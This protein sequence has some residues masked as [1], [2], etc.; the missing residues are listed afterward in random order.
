MHSPISVCIR[1][2]PEAARIREEDLRAV[3][4]HA[5]AA[6]DAAFAVSADRV[7]MYAVVLRRNAEMDAGMKLLERVKSLAPLG[8]VAGGMK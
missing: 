4:A 3:Q 6:A 2:G 8:S 7:T 5:R 1:I